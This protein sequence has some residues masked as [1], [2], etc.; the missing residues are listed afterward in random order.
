MTYPLAIVV[1][2]WPRLSET[3]IAQELVALEESG[4]D[5]E[6]WS[7]RYP[8]DKK[9]HPLHDRLKAPVRYLPEYLHED[10]E[11]V[12]KA[13]AIAQTLPGYAKAY[14]I[15]RRDLAR[16]RDINRVRR[17]GQALCSGR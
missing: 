4:L 13:R 12:W 7:L 15:W 5:F 16:D 11:R 6:L 2:G 14:D 9:T 8:T 17:F 3:F 1:K 10:P